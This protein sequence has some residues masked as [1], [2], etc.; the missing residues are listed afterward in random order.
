MAL[1]DFNEVVVK[2]KSFPIRKKCGAVA[3]DAHTVQA[4]LDAEKEGLAEPVFIGDASEIRQLLASRGAGTGYLVVPAS[5]LEDA[6]ARGAALA[7]EGSVD[8]LL[9]GALDT[10]VL[11]KAVVGKGAGLGTGRLMSHLA[12]I[13]APFY[14]KILVITDGGMVI[15]PD[16]EQKQA[17]VEN[18]AGALRGLGYDCPKVAC[19]AAVEKVHAGMPE[20]ADAAE[21]VR[22]NAD[23][24][25]KG[26]LV[27]GPISFDLAVSRESAA[28]KGYVSPVAGDADI[29]LVP[30]IASGN[31]LGKALMFA[32]GGRMAGLV[33]GARCPVV[34]TSRS[35]SAR[36]KFISIAFSAL[37]NQGAAL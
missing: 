10:S 1:N 32:A 29:L 14:H 37:L 16:L 9:K 4:V 25:I 21:L 11:L 18:A 26:C 35:A 30:D 19:L 6:A 20:T 2:V 23:G 17:I 7:G 24:L 28:A 12:F 3:P 8:F 34:V 27:A 33:A 5:S 22:R 36:E 15:R 13:S 31:I